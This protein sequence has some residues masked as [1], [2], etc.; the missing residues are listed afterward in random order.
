MFKE[1][2]H[3][4]ANKHYAGDDI[5]G[6]FRNWDVAFAEV[7]TH[8]GDQHGDRC[9]DSNNP[10]NGGDWVIQAQTDTDSESVYAGGDTKEE[11]IEN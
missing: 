7:D 5:G 8:E 3:S 4:E 1:N 2:L 9:N 6:L 11:I 10:E